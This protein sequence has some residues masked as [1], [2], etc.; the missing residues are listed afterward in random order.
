MQLLHQWRTKEGCVH[1]GIFELSRQQLDQVQ[2]LIESHPCITRSAGLR[3][4][5]AKRDKH[6]RLIVRVI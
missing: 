1:L 6:P 2:R 5:P 3:Q 4:S